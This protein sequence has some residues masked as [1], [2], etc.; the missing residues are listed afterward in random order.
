MPRRRRLRTRRTALS[1]PPSRRGRLIRSQPS[2]RHKRCE[3]CRNN[4]SRQKMPAAASPST[5]LLTRSASEGPQTLARVSRQDAYFLQIGF[6]LTRLPP[7]LNLALSILVGTKSISKEKL[8]R[9]DI[10]HAFFPKA[11]AFRILGLAT[12]RRA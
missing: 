8:C 5:A 2:S 12:S 10:R 3:N 4:R 1:R 11:P 9:K 6:C 7:L